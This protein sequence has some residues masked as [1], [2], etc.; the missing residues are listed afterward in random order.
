M[1]VIAKENTDSELRKRWYVIHVYATFEDKI[2]ANIMEQAEEHNLQDLFGEVVIPSETVTEV[3][4]G[5]KVDVDKKFFPGYI[6]IQMAMTDQTWHLVKNTNRVTGF[7]GGSG[8][9]KPVPLS[10]AEAKRFR[11]QL[12]EGFTETRSGVMYE[13]GETVNVIDGPFEGFNGVVEEVEEAHNKLKVS[14][15][16]FGRATPVELSFQQV[17]KG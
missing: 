13:V 7:L 16:I 17:E 9:G 2:A 12:E 15:S 4:R 11:A 14:V 5:Q 8:K 3:R 10:N 1:S 6:L